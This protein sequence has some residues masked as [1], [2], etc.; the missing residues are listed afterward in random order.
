MS[1]D[2]VTKVAW[3]LSSNLIMEIGS[4]LQK[5]TVRYL[6]GDI[7]GWFFCLKAIKMRIIQHLDKDE[8]EDLKEKESSMAEQK[9]NSQELGKL[10]EQYNTKIMDLLN[11]Y[12]YLIGEK[13]DT[14]HIRA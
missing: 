8:R 5:A 2:D 3:N 11:R 4:L 14:T 10:T 9:N 12:G 1:E 7:E 13:E 6:R